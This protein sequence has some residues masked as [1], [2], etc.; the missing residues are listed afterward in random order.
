MNDFQ[1]YE[2]K[3]KQKIKINLQSQWGI[4]TT[5][6]QYLTEQL[7][8]DYYIEDLNNIMNETQ[9]KSSTSSSSRTHIFFKKNYTLTTHQGRPYSGK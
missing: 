7:K 4:L 6:S 8:I 9:L 1:I 5:I 2:T 3:T